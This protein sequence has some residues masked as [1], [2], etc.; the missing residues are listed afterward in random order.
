MNV[1][2]ARCWAFLS[3]GVGLGQSEDSFVCF[4]VKPTQRACARDFL[5]DRKKT[6]K[7]KVSEQSTEYKSWWQAGKG[8]GQRESTAEGGVGTCGSR[9]QVRQRERLSQRSWYLCGNFVRVHAR[10]SHKWQKSAKN[11]PLHTLRPD[12]SP[13]LFVLLSRLY[14]LYLLHMKCSWSEIRETTRL[15][16]GHELV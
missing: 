16:N 6:K 5:R 14:M 9:I 10:D 3:M 13:Y 11:F 2:V 12:P 8:D 7:G 1:F 15:S 4:D